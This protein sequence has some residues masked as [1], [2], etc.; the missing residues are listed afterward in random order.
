MEHIFLA[1]LLVSITALGRE[2]SHKPTTT[3]EYR[4]CSSIKHSQVIFI[5]LDRYLVYLE[6]HQ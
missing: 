1:I 3:K 2:S 6:T 4:W 5:W